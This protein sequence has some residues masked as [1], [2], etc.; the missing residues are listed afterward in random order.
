MGNRHGRTVLRSPITY[1]LFNL[2]KHNHAGS[3]T[4]RH[5]AHF[6]FPLQLHQCHVCLSD[7]R[8]EHVDASTDHLASRERFSYDLQD[9][10]G[11]LISQI[12]SLIGCSIYIMVTNTPGG[13]FGPP[14]T[15]IALWAMA[16]FAMLATL[17]ILFSLNLLTLSEHV[18]VN[19]LLPFVTAFASYVWLGER[20]TRTQAVCCR[21]SPFFALERPQGLLLH[22]HLYCWSRDGSRPFPHP[23]TGEQGRRQE[24]RD[25][26]HVIWEAA[27]CRCFPFRDLPQSTA[28]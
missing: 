23:G 10:V 25:P 1:S 19:C 13:I 6:N 18:S 21:K 11:R 4:K 16:I 12:P 17:P 2:H 5:R 26:R 9:T 3:T 8:D 20:F 24:R 14:G 15:R 27:R 22:S 28:V 7:Q